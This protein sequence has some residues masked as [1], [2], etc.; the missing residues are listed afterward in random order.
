MCVLFI[1]LFILL[2]VRQR[3][4]TI[5]T[6]SR[7]ATETMMSTELTDRQKETAV[8]RHS[9]ALF[10]ATLVFIAQFALIGAVIYLFY[11]GFVYLFPATEKTLAADL[12]SPLVITVMTLG[13]IAYVWVRKNISKRL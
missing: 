6:V 1:E 13:A 7:A 5:F 11:I 3:V 9:M 10:R 2:R 4:D 8:R 12:V